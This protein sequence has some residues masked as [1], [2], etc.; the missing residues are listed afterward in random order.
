VKIVKKSTLIKVCEKHKIII[1]IGDTSI[2]LAEKIN[3]FLK[4]EIYIKNQRV[5]YL[6]QKD[7]RLKLYLEEKNKDKLSGFYKICSVCN[8][9]KIKKE[10]QTLCHGIQ[11]KCIDC[12]KIEYS[13]KL[14]FEE[15]QQLKKRNKII[16]RM[17]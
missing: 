17:K 15:K 13:K 5:V 4:A 3:T 7:F 14:L 6:R 9:G 11:T 1:E 12:R 8:V 2:K 16:E 10:F